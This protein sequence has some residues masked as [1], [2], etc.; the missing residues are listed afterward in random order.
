MNITLKTSEV[1]AVIARYIV[2][3]ISTPGTKSKSLFLRI[4]WFTFNSIMSPHSSHSKNIMVSLIARILNSFKQKSKLNLQVILLRTIYFPPVFYLSFISDYLEFYL[5]SIERQQAN[6]ECHPS[7][8]L[9]RCFY[10][11]FFCALPLLCD[12]IFIYF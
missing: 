7:S 8:F 2:P 4:W 12:F 10:C 6:S 9:S 1:V 3:G 5:H 11:F